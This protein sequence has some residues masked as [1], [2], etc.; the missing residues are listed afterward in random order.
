MRKGRYIGRTF[1]A[2]WTC[3]RRE[4][5]DRGRDIYFILRN[6]YNGTEIRVSGQSMK[7]IAEGKTTVSKLVS[8]QIVRERHKKG[9]F[10]FYGK[11]HD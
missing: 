5:V 1:C 4:Y 6:D 9:I 7:K 8:K 2:Y 10:S 11:I 3:I